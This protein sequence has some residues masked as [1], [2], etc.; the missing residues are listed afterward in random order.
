MI[1]KLFRY[2]LILISCF[3]SLYCE[4]GNR[5]ISCFPDSVINV[6]ANLELPQFQSLASVGGWAYI[7]SGPSS[8]T[9]GLILVRTAQGFKAYDR[10]APH[11][12][13]GM[14]TTLE[15]LNEIYLY[16]PEDKAKW[17]LST[18]QPLEVTDK[19]PKTYNAQLSGNT[20]YIS[21]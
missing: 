8:G 12:C 18:G 9:R 1:K 21:Y 7:K 6:T 19:P 20:V 14:N 17:I 16:C 4:N 13:P 10:N 5:T 11:I 3:L 2:L 15:V